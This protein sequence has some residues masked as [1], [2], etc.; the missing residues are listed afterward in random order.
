MSTVLIT[1]SSGYLGTQL[2]RRLEADDAVQTIVGVDLAEPQEPFSKLRFFKLDCLG[3]MEA[4][5][6]LQ[7][8]DAV[9][10]LVFVLNMT[11]NKTRMR[12][13]NVGSLENVLEH[14]HNH[15]VGRLV[16][17]SSTT[18]YGAHADNPVP[19]TEADPLRATPSYQYAYD[20]IMV[21]ARLS[22]YQDLH[23]DCD[24]VIARP[25]I[26]LGPH[27]QNFLGRYVDR[28]IIPW[29]TRPAPMNLLHEEDI[30]DALHHLITQA[31]R[32]VYNVAPAE[33]VDLAQVLKESG[34]IVISLPSWLL[35]PL[36][37]LAWWLR[38]TL[39]TEAPG[40]MIDFI[41]HSW[42]ADGSKIERET[43]FRYR[44]TS[45]QALEDFLQRD[46]REANG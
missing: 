9:V 19:L 31:P 25:A 45:R 22:V 24:V 40:A 6:S 15:Q 11:H 7:P 33:A 27:A 37:Q 34:R 41:K 16:V 30:A 5:F 38:I 46:Q 39:L 28:K 4:A 14:C 18:A 13:I 21:E 1:G 42:A 20:K 3:D 35:R 8:I 10:H 32:G 29:T 23:P 43:T 17:T 26:V 44:H 12:R 2:C 36:T